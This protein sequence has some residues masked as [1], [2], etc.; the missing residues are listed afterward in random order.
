MCGRFA[1]SVKTEDIE[2]LK[3]GFTAEEELTP[4]YNIA[5]TQN[6]AV[7]LNDGK[8]S[9]SMARWGL[10]P[11]WAKDESIGNK[12]INARAET[13]LEKPSFSKS[14]KTKRCLIFADAFYEW[15]KSGDSKRK[16]PYLVKMKNSE[17]F[18]FA[19][20]WDKWI[21]PNGESVIT[22]I[23]ITTEPNELMKVIHH[24]MPVILDEE[25][26][27]KWLAKES[28]NEELVSLL[29]PYPDIEMTAYEVST[30]V[31]SPTADFPG[32]MSPIDF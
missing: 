25:A 3:P 15:K 14:L 2:K 10:I 29:K 7:S 31:N 26:R 8:N 24:R 9:V 22:A 5:P 16:T 17:P 30:I 11:F 27:T 20:L 19:G 12:M 6:I 28:K 18:T 1:L 13:L 23:I 21:N 32:C 4:R